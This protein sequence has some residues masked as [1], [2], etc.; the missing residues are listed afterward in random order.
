MHS[1]NVSS[2]SKSM[3]GT[4]SSNNTINSTI[5]NPKSIASVNVNSGV[6]SL[7]Y[8]TT[9]T[10]VHQRPY[11]PSPSLQQR[12][13][14][15][16]QLAIETFNTIQKSVFATAEPL[17]NQGKNEIIG[18]KMASEN[19]GFQTL[20]FG[21]VES[22]TS[23]ENA[24]GSLL[25]VEDKPLPS[26]LPSTISY[27]PEGSTTPLQ[28]NNSSKIL[29]HGP[30]STD[31]SNN[32]TFNYASN[33]N[34]N[35]DWTSMVTV[36]TLDVAGSV[37][38]YV[39]NTN[40]N[41]APAMMSSGY[42]PGSSGGLATATSSTL[43]S[44]GS[45]QTT[46]T[47][48]SI[49]TDDVFRPMP[50]VTASTTTTNSVGPL[51]STGSRISTMPSTIHVPINTSN[52]A[53][54]EINVGDFKS[55]H[56][57]DPFLAL[58]GNQPP[59]TLALGSLTNHHNKFDNKIAVDGFGYVSQDN[60]LIINNEVAPFSNP[61]FTTTTS[62]AQTLSLA[63]N[64]PSGTQ[65]PDDDDFGDFS[66]F[67]GGAAESGSSAHHIDTVSSNNNTFQSSNEF[68]EFPT[69]LEKS[70]TSALDNHPKI[71]T[72]G[73]SN[74]KID[75]LVLPLEG[76][77]FNTETSNNPSTVAFGVLGNINST[78]SSQSG[79]DPTVGFASAFPTGNS[80]E[81]AP[82]QDENDDFGDFSD[83]PQQ[84]IINSQCYEPASDAFSNFVQSSDKYN[85]IDQLA[86]NGDFSNKFPT[87]DTPS[88]YDVNDTLAYAI[89][90]K[91]IRMCNDVDLS[92]ETGFPSTSTE[93]MLE[94]S[95][96][97]ALDALADVQDT[98]LPTLA[99]PTIIEESPVL[100]APSSSKSE[101][102]VVNEIA[103]YD[104]PSD[105][106]GDFEGI[107]SDIQSAV[108]S[109]SENPIPPIG[110]LQITHDDG[111]DEFVQI[112]KPLDPEPEETAFFKANEG[113][114]SYTVP[115]SVNCSAPVTSNENSLDPFSIPA[116]GTDDED[117]DFGA[118]EG[119]A[120]AEQTH[121]SGDILSGWD[122]LDAL[123]VV[124]DAPIPSICQPLSMV[125]P[126]LHQDLEKTDIV[127]QFSVIENEGA[128]SVANTTKFHTSND[129]F[130]ENFGVADTAWDA[131]DSPV[132]VNATGP[133][134]SFSEADATLISESI[135]DSALNTIVGS[136]TLQIAEMNETSSIRQGSQH[137][138]SSLDFVNTC[139]VGP[140]MSSFDGGFVNDDKLK[141]S[142][143]LES[144]LDDT[145][146]DFGD[147]ETVT[148]A[149]INTDGLIEPKNDVRLDQV[150]LF[151]LAISSV[152]N[153]DSSS[154]F[155]ADEEPEPFVGKQKSS[156]LD[157]IDST[158][159]SAAKS[160]SSVSDDL[161]TFEDAV[162]S[163]GIDTFQCNIN[164]VEH[165]SDEPTTLFASGI[166]PDSMSDD[167][168]DSLG[169]NMAPEVDL[170]SLRNSQN[171][172]KNTD[173]QLN[174]TSAAHDPSEN[175]DCF[176]DFNNFSQINGMQQPELLPP[177][178]MSF[179]PQAEKPKCDQL[180]GNE[181][182]DAFGDFEDCAWSQPDQLKPD[183]LTIS[184]YRD[185]TEVP[186]FPLDSIDKN[187]ANEA[188]SF[189]DFANFHATTLIE[190]DSDVNLPSNSFSPVASNS[191]V[192]FPDTSTDEEFG[193]F[194]EAFE[195]NTNNLGKKTDDD[196]FGNF[197][198]FV[199]AP[200]QSSEVLNLQIHHKPDVLNELRGN[201][202]IETLDSTND[203]KREKDLIVE[204]SR[205]IPEAFLHTRGD[206]GILSFGNCFDS[207][208]GFENPLSDK[209]RFRLDRCRQLLRLLSVSHSTLAS[210]YW[211]NAL[212]II[213][214]KLRTG[215]SLLKEA[216]A[217]SFSENDSIHSSLQIY[218]EC[219]A[220]L[221]RVSRFMCATVGDILMIEESVPLSVD[222]FDSQ[223]CSIALMKDA[224]EIERLWKEIESHSN[225]SLNF[226]PT[227]LPTLLDI[228][229]RN[230]ALDTSQIQSVCQ[231][232][233]QP[234]AAHAHC[235]STTSAVEWEKKTF[236]ACSANFLANTCAFYDIHTGI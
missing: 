49:I 224:I 110:A 126:S 154:I 232:T 173:Q 180:D 214:D 106:F 165:T 99:S 17:C 192:A 90:G 146:D 56:H 171:S 32:H 79:V 143:A 129:L 102:H 211:E 206:T 156:Q 77:S 108:P 160:L 174:G 185:S 196:V 53:N 203:L 179:C 226:K 233:L 134:T 34:S 189:G 208:I 47:L 116:K 213:R 85:K 96:W 86:V 215:L 95:G 182:S 33:T 139:H 128:T 220:E 152:T 14:P 234:L 11:D 2:D 97:D 4:Y 40:H 166:Q 210:A 42:P 236:M 130:A 89:D 229:T 66:N 219:L 104:D 188:D 87:I 68:G 83:C 119:M 161:S 181:E 21:T 135:Q 61:E 37:G 147:F 38:T 131:L 69:S 13:I 178:V 65:L 162:S 202:V 101:S 187:V 29:E 137:V 80:N 24:F 51:L 216:S 43:G 16:P 112:H 190:V 141:S 127:C 225:I 205:Q 8:Q 223:W 117:D 184:E 72:M 138:S 58:G 57:Q 52:S 39:N 9:D 5:M 145:D 94:P 92:K 75:T 91:S 41:V 27:A 19:D 235:N 7:S 62:F 64:I 15:E 153:V 84:S 98:P 71:S 193:N 59:Q 73:S 230:A 36:P 115:A 125:V 148:A 228:R 200:Y 30:G 18:N 93:P 35:S 118:F 136:E 120:N 199:E 67:D 82:I 107:S 204:H 63:S 6:M 155:K 140:A 183:T 209:Q 167:P 150:G 144:V 70:M 23:I 217:S 113:T 221:V 60:N 105:S 227:S 20:S 81:N 31:A 44:L 55:T 222:T 74:S 133:S 28:N 186:V 78:L 48:P 124:H 191:L 218:K 142:A 22:L 157:R 170:C 123:S 168:F 163:Y 100:L 3:T 169:G 177:N 46:S 10:G 151:D 45:F 111:F 231:F 50:V 164:S 26:L 122:A 198:T 175:S 12:K 103:N 76:N 109:D 172:E 132:D 212:S 149:T 201:N 114:S 1:R 54:D 88:S 194:E 25:Q 195:Q 121:S 207:N 159:Y 197:A 158:Y 176:G